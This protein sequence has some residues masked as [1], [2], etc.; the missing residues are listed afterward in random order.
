MGT[1]C[2][3]STKKMNVFNKVDYRTKSRLIPK[4]K[5]RRK[6]F[7]MEKEDPKFMRFGLEDIV[8]RADMDAGLCAFET[9]DTIY[10]DGRNAVDNEIN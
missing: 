4:L 2:N 7:Y 10:N 6:K 3:D 8:R 1:F 5:R 9:I